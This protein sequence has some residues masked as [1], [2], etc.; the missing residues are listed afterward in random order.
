[1]YGKL[2]DRSRKLVEHR[3]DEKLKAQR[4]AV[5]TCFV[6]VASSQADRSSRAGRLLLGPFALEQDQVA[7]PPSPQEQGQDQDDDAGEMRHEVRLGV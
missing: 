3:L 4:H 6:A 5:A 2:L 7:R 1:M